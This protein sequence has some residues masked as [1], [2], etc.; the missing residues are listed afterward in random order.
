VRNNKGTAN[1]H[2][3]ALAMLTGDVHTTPNNVTPGAVL[4]ETAHFVAASDTFR[5]KSVVGITSASDEY[6]I[7][8]NVNWWGLDNITQAGQM[9]KISTGNW[10]HFVMV[11]NNTDK[12]IRLYVNKVLATNPEWETKTG[13]NFTEQDNLGMIIGAFQN[14]VGLNS[15]NETWAKAMTGKVDQVR[16][17]NTLYNLEL[18]GR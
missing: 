6:K 12:T 5:V 2:A 9:V 18:A 17:Y 4:L 8:D 16:V 11:W 15:V 1:E 3:T 13:A 14:N 10:A 7:E